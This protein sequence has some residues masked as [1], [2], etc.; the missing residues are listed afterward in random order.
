M[1]KYKELLEFFMVNGHCNVPVKHNKPLVNWIG[2]Q[3]KEYHNF[4]NNE[5]SQ[6]NEKRILLLQKAGLLLNERYDVQ[7]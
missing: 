2:R 3:R 1:L 7:I 6:L 5:K 4:L